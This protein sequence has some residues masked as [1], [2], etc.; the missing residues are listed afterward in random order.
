MT[1]DPKAVSTIPYSLI[2]LDAILED[3]QLE[4]QKSLVRNVVTSIPSINQQQ[5]FLHLSIT[6]TLWATALLCK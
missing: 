6:C 1:L 3:R 2:K 5:F 4:I